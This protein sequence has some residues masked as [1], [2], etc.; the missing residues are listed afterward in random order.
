MLE[1][2]LLCQRSQQ[3]DGQGG[4]RNFKC[5]LYILM[6]GQFPSMLTFA[7]LTVDTQEQMLKEKSISQSPVR[8]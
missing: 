2:D 6:K 8:N 4:V 5:T 3:R 7:T 1:E